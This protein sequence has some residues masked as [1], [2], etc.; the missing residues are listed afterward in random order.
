MIRTL[1]AIGLFFAAY[2]AGAS[3]LDEVRTRIDAV[4]QDWVKAI[5]AG[6]F[7]RSVEPYA[8]DA[9]FITRDG[10]IM[11]GPAAIEKA[12]QI[13]SKELRLLDGSLET[14]DL[15]AVGSLYYEY[16]HSA[17]RWQQ[18]DGTIRPTA[19]Q[20]LTIWRHDPDGTWRV[21]RNLTL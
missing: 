2:A 21:I 1:T 3:E 15:R 12:A 5:Q 10:K 8:E 16:G 14:D 6:D 4:N 20:F 13:R 9:I 19:G 11:I 17:L 7:R 18:P